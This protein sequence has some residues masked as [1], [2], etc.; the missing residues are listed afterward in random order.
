[1]RVEASETWKQLDEAVVALRAQGIGSPE[2][3]VVLGSG[4]G[5]FVRALSGSAAIS[6]GQIPHMPAVSVKGHEGRLVLGKV[7]QVEVACLQGRAHLYE[8]H[9]V[10][11]VVFGVR[12][13]AMLGVRAVLLTNAAGG[14][15]PGFAPGDLMV[16]RDH[17]NLLGQNP[18]TGPSLERMG[19]RFV[20]LS[21]A[22]DLRVAEAGLRAGL[23]VGVPLHEGVY[24]ALPGPSYE[25]PAEIRMLRMLGADVVGMST[26]PEV[27]ALNHLRVPVGALSCITNLAA[28]LGEAPLSHEE[29]E[30]TA[31]E[32]SQRFQRVLA[33]WVE[34]TH[35][36]LQ[37]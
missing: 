33:R 19:P 16:V 37:L 5:E 1:M 3:G 9:S 28:G 21:H 20:D 27:I 11:R 2:M 22:Y 17:L 12:L 35:E 23:D 25:T 7:G 10:D 32:S 34:R 14:I 8:G 30:R 29:V 24:A 18:L 15:R 31:A 13:L 26:V 6:F 4:L 36:V